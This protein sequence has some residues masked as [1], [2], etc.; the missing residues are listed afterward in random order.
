MSDTI[1]G[2]LLTTGGGDPIPLLQARLVIGR[3]EDCDICLRFPNISGQHC[4]LTFQDGF[5]VLRD[6]GSTNGTK[7]NGERIS[8]RPLRPGDEINISKRR[9]IIQYELSEE[10]R[11]R[12]EEMMGETCN[13]FNQSLLEKAGLVSRRRE[14]D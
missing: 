5:W 4:E 2:Q 1:N 11:G 3:R 10:A 12:L 7:V 14:A 6:L 9:Y 8:V 13:I